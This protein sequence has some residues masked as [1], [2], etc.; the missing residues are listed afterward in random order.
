MKI[1]DKFI[2]KLDFRKRGGLI[3]VVVQDVNTKDILMLAYANR[4][5]IENT[6]ETSKAW[7]WSHSRNKLWMKGE[8]SG[9]IQHVKDILVDCDYDSLIYLVD[10]K[11]PAC[12]TGNRTC[13]HNRLYAQ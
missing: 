9:N 2:D 8:E 4:N 13:F 12:H 11:N 7:F 5:A 6:I 1:D 3:P 10:S